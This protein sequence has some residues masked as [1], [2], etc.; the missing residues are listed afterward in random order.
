MRIFRTRVR[1]IERYIHPSL[2]DQFVRVVAPFDEVPA[3]KLKR[4]ALSEPLGEGELYLPPPLGPVSRFNSEGRWIIHRDLQ[5]EQRYIR[6]VYWRWTQFKGRNE[7]EEME[8]S[9]DI[10]RPCYPRTFVSPPAEE[11]IGFPIDGKLY[12]ATEAVSLPAAKDRL[13]HQVNLM[14]ELFGSCEIVRA[15]GKSASPARTHRRW[16]FL[17]SGPFKKGDVPRALDQVFSRLN[18][19]DKIIL[20]ERQDFL[21][22]LQPQE[23]AEGQGGFNDYLAY[24]FPQY[25]RVV[26]ESLRRDN[27]IYIFRDSWEK[28]SRFTK[29]E[30][31][32]SGVHDARILHTKGWQG[33]LMAA[34]RA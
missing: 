33:R 30:V 5:K 12:A 8:D 1:N 3:A 11:I 16:V 21:T 22:E 17:P 28:F 19:S 6:T 10:F 20:S 18:E 26:L 15:D 32:D 2:A 4:L 23:I 24:V 27:A 14:L 9:R 25:G 7:T 13:Q 31:L 34:L 29:R